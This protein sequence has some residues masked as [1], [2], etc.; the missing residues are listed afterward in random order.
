[1]TERHDTLI[2]MIN[3][4]A[5]PAVGKSLLAVVS[6]RL[7]GGVT[8]W[9]KREHTARLSAARRRLDARCVSVQDVRTAVA[10]AHENGVPVAVRSGG[11]NYAGY[12]VGP[13]LVVN[14]GG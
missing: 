5:L 9:S 11:H 1:M 13:G 6:V 10:W 8:P 4:V 14:V 2:G 7:T 3:V 12:S